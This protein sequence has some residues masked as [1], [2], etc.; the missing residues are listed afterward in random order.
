MKQ[1]AEDAGEVLKQ[2]RD[3][4][5]E[6]RDLGSAV[7]TKYQP[8]LR[9]VDEELAAVEK[10]IGGHRQRHS[11]LESLH[12]A[13]VDELGRREAELKQVRQEKLELKRKE[14]PIE[15]LLTTARSKHR[16]FKNNK[17][18]LQGAQELLTEE[19]REVINESETNH[20]L[21]IEYSPVL[22][23]R[24]RRAE[25]TSRKNKMLKKREE[26]GQHY[27]LLQEELLAKERTTGELRAGHLEQSER[28]KE[29][30]VELDH[31]E[32]QLGSLPRSPTPES[33]TRGGSRTGPPTLGQALQIDELQ[34]NIAATRSQISDL[35]DRLYRNLQGRDSPDFELPPSRPDTPVLRRRHSAPAVIGIPE[36]VVELPP[37]SPLESHPETQ[38]EV[39]KPYPVP[40]A[41]RWLQ[42]YIRW[43]PWVA[44]YVVKGSLLGGGFMTYVMGKKAW[45]AELKSDSDIENALQLLL[46]LNIDQEVSRPP[47]CPV[48]SDMSPP[49]TTNTVN[50]PGFG[51]GF[52][53]PLK[54]ELGG[55]PSGVSTRWRLFGSGGRF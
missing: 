15:D 26:L 11:H 51:P 27:G 37:D 40:D 23:V 33:P 20:R 10:W 45:Y 42:S 21:R 4:E 53:P 8:A 44:P 25:L 2:Y 9:E 41:F 19:L 31:M 52:F 48:M 12:S 35:K 3:K 29:L 34:K 54:P 5:A 30:E 22:Q 18:K 47:E 1:G 24:R 6:T 16:E 7:L 17:Q 50:L 13:E 39:V 32:Q 14:T 28:L 46:S 43:L 49:A 36:P 55:F 38:T